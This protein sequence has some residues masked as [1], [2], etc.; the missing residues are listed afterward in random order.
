MKKLV[1][2][3]MTAALCASMA[4]TAFAADINQDSEPKTGNTA[5]TTSKAPTYT[6]VIPES[7]EIA[8]DV[9]ENALGRSNTSRVI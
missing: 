1:A 2:G 9:E 6:I 3:I 5:L 7:A 8:F 4:S